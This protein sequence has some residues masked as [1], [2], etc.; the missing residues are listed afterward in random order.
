[1]SSKPITELVQFIQK[2]SESLKI[3]ESKLENE[4]LEIVVEYMKFYGQIAAREAAIQTGTL[5]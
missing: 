5:S 4:L 2:L 3:F 1:M